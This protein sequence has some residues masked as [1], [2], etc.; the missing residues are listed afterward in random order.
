[1]K[2]QLKSSF[3]LEVEKIRLIFESIDEDNNK[4]LSPFE[5]TLVS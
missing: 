1:M 4:Y 3:D 5:L 2:V